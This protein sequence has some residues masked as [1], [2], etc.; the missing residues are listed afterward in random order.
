MTNPKQLFLLDGVGAFVSAFMLGIVLMQFESFFGI[1]RS[2]L[3]ILA[4]IPI[5]FIAYDILAYFLGQGKIGSL[6]K[7]IATLNIL[8]CILSIG[9]AIFHLADLTVFGWIYILGEIAI[10][11]GIAFYEVKVARSL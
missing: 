8:Y 2:A 4:T 3:I 6:L 10:I 11:L 9:M 5:L 1:P 7:G